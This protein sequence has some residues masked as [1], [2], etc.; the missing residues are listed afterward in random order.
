MDVMSIVNAN[1]HS[2]ISEMRS[3]SKR[4]IIIVEQIKIID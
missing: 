2:H 4:Y 1:K 3:W